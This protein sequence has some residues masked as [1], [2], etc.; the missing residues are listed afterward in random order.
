[1]SIAQGIARATL[2]TRPRVGVRVFDLA[3][4][5]HARVRHSSP[6]VGTHAHRRQDDPQ[7]TPPPAPSA[8]WPE[9]WA[10]RSLVDTA[11][12]QTAR[13][14]RRS[15]PWPRCRGPST[16]SS[17]VAWVA[18]RSPPTAAYATRFVRGG[19]R[20]VPRGVPR[21]RALSSHCLGVHVVLP[22]RAVLPG[23]RGGG[24][25]AHARA[26]HR[27]PLGPPPRGIAKSA[28]RP[29]ACLRCDAPRGRRRRRSR[30]GRPHPRR[31]EASP[32]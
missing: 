8:S 27:G 19:Q 32:G 24:R 1:M 12:G 16:S 30:H 13:G 15:S 2:W 6:C 22:P 23:R 18:A 10:G 14:P 3:A 17:S 7:L 31:P 26:E 20:G 29:A 28:R 4:Y 25:P 5:G 11:G 21:R 9:C